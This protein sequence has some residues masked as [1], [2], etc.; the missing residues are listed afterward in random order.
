VFKGK[1]QIMATAQREQFER[2]LCPIDLEGDSDEALRYAIALALNGH[3]RLC[4]CHCMPQS[5][6]QD[7]KKYRNALASLTSCVGRHILPDFSDQCDDLKWY[8]IVLKGDPLTAIPSYCNDNQI[9]LVVMRS[10]KRSGLAGALG[11]TAETLV[12]TCPCSVLVTGPDEREF[13]GKTTNEIEIHEILVGYDFTPEA[14]D[15]LSIGLSLA[16]EFQ[17]KLDLMH[18]LRYAT[19]S[20]AGPIDPEEPQLGTLTS[21]LCKVVPA[22]ARNRCEINQVFA[23]G[24]P[25]EQILRYSQSHPVDLIS[26]GAVADPSLLYKLLGSTANRV[27]RGAP[28]PVL[29]ARASPACAMAE[30]AR[31]SGIAN[32]C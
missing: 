12:R 8:P 10:R 26:L 19:I 22:R 21:L 7:G 20:G 23:E 18:V 6:F 1:E 2:I 4:V 32:L 14:D 28:C 9:D 27:L 31:A 13:A 30:K 3:A 16:Q 25:A 24:D 29:I 17:S 5:D 11:S 15:A